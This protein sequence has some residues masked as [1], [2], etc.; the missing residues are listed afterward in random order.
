[1]ISG[2]KLFAN[3]VKARASFGGFTFANKTKIIM[4]IKEKDCIFETYRRRDQNITQAE[5]AVRVTHI[6]TGVYSESDVARSYH[7]NR[8]LAFTKLVIKMELK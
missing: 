6:E 3:E 4:D 2:R 8:E 1:L 5:S 7:K